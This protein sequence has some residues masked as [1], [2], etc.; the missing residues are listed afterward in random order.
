MSKG[1]T[2]RSIRIDDPL[3]DKAQAEASE[4]GDNLSDIIRAVLIEYV[5][6][7]AN[8]QRKAMTSEVN[9]MTTAERLAVIEA[10]PNN[11]AYGPE[12]RAYLLAL[13]RELRADED[14]K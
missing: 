11:L 6:T 4:R 5:E 1:T 13:V 7:H 9:I 10:R 8:E 2:R 3:W 12:D 14:S